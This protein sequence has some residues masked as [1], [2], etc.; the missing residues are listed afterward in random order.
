MNAL[1]AKN[2]SG[3]IDIVAVQNQ[4]LGLQN[5]PAGSLTTF[6]VDPLQALNQSGEFVFSAA[7]VGASSPQAVIKASLSR[8]E[9]ACPADFDNNGSAEVAD[10]FAFL[11]SWFAQNSSA[12]FDENGQVQVNDIFAFLSAWFAGC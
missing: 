7:F 6:I 9:P 1:I 10:I 4:A 5:G 8:S 12:D 11:S 3:E 2:G